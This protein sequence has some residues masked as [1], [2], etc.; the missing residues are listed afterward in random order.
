M[1]RP[2]PSEEVPYELQRLRKTMPLTARV[3]EAK[4][5]ELPAGAGRSQDW[6]D[7]VGAL[8][9]PL[10]ALGE[11]VA[12]HDRAIAGALK[13]RPFAE[14]RTF[15]DALRYGAGTRETVSS[16]PDAALVAT[17]IHPLA[18]ITHELIGE[19]GQ[20]LTWNRRVSIDEGRSTK[21][22][23]EPLRAL[24]AHPDAGAFIH[25]Y[26]KIIRYHA[27]IRRGDA[28]ALAETLNHIVTRDSVPLTVRQAAVRVIL[29]SNHERISIIKRRKA[30]ERGERILDDWEPGLPIVYN[31]AEDEAQRAK[32]V[33][34]AVEHH[35]AFGDQPHKLFGQLTR[36]LLEVA[37]AQYDSPDNKSRFRFSGYSRPLDG[38]L[39]PLTAEELQ[40]AGGHLSDAVKRLASNTRLDAPQRR[41]MLRAYSQTLARAYAQP[42][43][44][45]ERHDAIAR[46][47]KELSATPWRLFGR[48]GREVRFRKSARKTTASLQA[49]TRRV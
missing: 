41:K 3:I 42:Y 46:V 20:M 5:K 47:T 1:D 32:V 15:V 2:A 18:P 12:F 24:V 19:C 4:A 9:R 6:Q 37:K 22:L 38:R 23:V 14:T 34:A 28:A 45:A 29:K 39:G 16:V 49:K 11:L 7:R 26:S 25:D 21:S 8:T 44:R 27:G 13:D 40:E 33:D 31:H 43:G 35:A 17:S 30:A 10:H 48:A 36:A